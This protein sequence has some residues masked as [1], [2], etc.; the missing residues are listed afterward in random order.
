MVDG[1]NWTLAAVC[2]ALAVALY[3][4]VTARWRREDRRILELMIALRFLAW[5]KPRQ[6][7]R[8]AALWLD[9]GWSQLVADYPE[10]EAFRVSQL[11]KL[12]ASDGDGR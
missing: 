12:D 6:P 9:G 4:E 3:R 5:S 1:I 10:Y 2:M 8:F 7:D 11:V